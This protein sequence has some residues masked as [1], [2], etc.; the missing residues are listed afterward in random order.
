MSDTGTAIEAAA[1]LMATNPGAG[2][3]A[4]EQHAR[5]PDG[6]C[7][8]CADPLA[9]WPCTMAAIARR[10]VALCGVRPGGAAGS[11]VR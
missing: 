2:E 10:A 7:A 11:R 4:L 1:E 6:R 5:R 3:R 9:R 8:G